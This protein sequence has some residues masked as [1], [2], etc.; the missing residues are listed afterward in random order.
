MTEQSTYRYSKVIGIGHFQSKRGPTATLHHFNQQHSSAELQSRDHEL[1]RE[2]LGIYWKPSGQQTF[3]RGVWDL[4]L[5][6]QLPKEADSEGVA[7][8]TMKII[9]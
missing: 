6:Q 3:T 1:L 9:A 2:P 8:Q 7:V 4:Q 5:P